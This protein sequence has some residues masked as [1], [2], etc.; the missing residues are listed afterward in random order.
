MA[1]GSVFGSRRKENILATSNQSCQS[2]EHALGTTPEL[3]VSL[4]IIIPRVKSNGA[5]GYTSM[6]IDQDEMFCR[7]HL[8]PVRRLGICD[9]WS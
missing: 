9:E 7:K 8:D 4:K 3:R 6:I 1:K 2:C 5:I